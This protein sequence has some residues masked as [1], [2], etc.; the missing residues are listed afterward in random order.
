MEERENKRA[1]ER[2]S[3]ITIEREIAEKDVDPDKSIFAIL[4]DD[5]WKKI[6]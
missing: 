4:G 6:V 3:E 5:L 1:I 2:E